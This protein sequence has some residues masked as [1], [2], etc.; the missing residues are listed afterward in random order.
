MSKNYKA[1]VADLIIHFY[2]EYQIVLTEP[3]IWLINQILQTSDQHFDYYAM[4][5]DII[6]VTFNPRT[7][8]AI[9]RYDN[10][11]STEILAETAIY[12]NAKSRLN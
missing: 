5:E 10:A 8:I 1:S 9:D 6:G 2:E 3:E 4:I 11:L 7:I 12:H